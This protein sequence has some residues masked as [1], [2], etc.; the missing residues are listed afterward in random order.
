VIPDGE[1]LMKLNLVRQEE[2]LVHVEC[3][4]EIKAEFVGTETDPMQAVLGPLVFSH[5][6]MLDLEKATY[7]DSAGLGW[8]VVSHKHFVENN[9]K[10]IL[11]S[12]SPQVYQV[13][14][15][16]RLPLILNIAAD[17]AAARAMANG[18]KR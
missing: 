17:E 2:G 3:E 15:I 7:I 9:G 10:L 18:G 14:E 13:L 12:V 8:L 6:V 16:V 1:W 11:H 5:T 4:G